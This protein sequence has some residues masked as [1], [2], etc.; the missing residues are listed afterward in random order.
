MTPF[1]LATAVYM[2]MKLHLSPQQRY[3]RMLPELLTAVA[4]P[5]TR[6][7]PGDVPVLHIAYT[8]PAGRTCRV[9]DAGTV[10]L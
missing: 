7:Q 1:A 5:L 6:Q 3:P 2:F 8:I 4:A 9:E 10:G